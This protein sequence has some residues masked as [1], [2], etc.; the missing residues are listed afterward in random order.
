MAIR[1]LQ[2]VA[3]LDHPELTPYRTLR[4]YEDHRRDRIFVAEG[5]KVVRRLLESPLTVVSVLMPEKW[6]R[7]YEPLL[8]AKPEPIDVYTAS[9]KVLERLTG[10]TMYQGVLAVGRMPAAWTLPEALERTAAPRLFVAVE[11]LSSAENLG[12]LVRNCAAFRAQCLLVG[13][14]SGSPWLRRAVRAGMGTIFTLPTVEPPSLVLALQALRDA[15]IHCVAAH[16][17]LRGSTIVETRLTGD[18]CLVFGS[19]GYG[20]TASVLHACSAAAAVPMRPDVDSL[21]VAS[22]AAVFLYEVNRQRGWMENVQGP[23]DAAR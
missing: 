18:V 16:P 13:E 21:N 14:T 15:G 22:A 17:H 4:Q 23:D 1:S 11:G 12:A 19:E 9:K 2:A 6:A 3:S 5:E 8:R 10:F 7:E 20:L